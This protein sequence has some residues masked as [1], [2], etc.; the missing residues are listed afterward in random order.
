VS[1]RAKYTYDIN[2]PGLLHARILRSPHAHAR[3]VSL[4]LGPAQKAPA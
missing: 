3:L 2:R 1:G 4:D